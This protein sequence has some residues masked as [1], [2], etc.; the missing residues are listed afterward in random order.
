MNS[1]VALVS[2]GYLMLNKKKLPNNKAMAATGLSIDEQTTI[3]STTSRNTVAICSS[4]PE[5]NTMY[6]N[7]FLRNLVEHNEKQ[8]NAT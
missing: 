5:T 6:K 7:N 3:P 1:S 8:G 4:H 2:T